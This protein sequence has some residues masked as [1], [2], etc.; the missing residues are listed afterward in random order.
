MK[1]Q[2]FVVST[3]HLSRQEVRVDYLYFDGK[4]WASP[5]VLCVYTNITD[6]PWTEFQTAGVEGVTGGRRGRGGGGGQQRWG[7]SALR[8]AA[9][10]SQ[11]SV[12]Y[13]VQSVSMQSEHPKKEQLDWLDPLVHHPAEE[14]AAA[15]LKTTKFLRKEVWKDLMKTWEN[16]KIQSDIKSVGPGRRCRVFKI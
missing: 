6:E 10:R 11:S 12:I 2:S 15:S 3:C 14:P 16:F 1:A 5:I 7:N 13:T 4:T 9:P 8:L